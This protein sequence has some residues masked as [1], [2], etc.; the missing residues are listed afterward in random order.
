MKKIIFFLLILLLPSV[1]AADPFKPYLHNPEVPSNPG[2]ELYGRYSTSLF[3]GAATYSYTIVVPSGRNGLTPSITIDYNNQRA[4]QRSIVGS[5][6]QITNNYVFRDVNSTPNDTTDDFFT[7]VLNGVHE[8]VYDDGYRVKFDNFYKI[9]NTTD[10]LVTTKSGVQYSFGTKVVSDSRTLKWYLDNITDTYGNQIYYS[11]STDP[12]PGDINAVYLDNITYNN[13]RTRKIEFSY[14]TRPDIRRVYDQG[15]LFEESSRLQNISVYA[16]TLVRSYVLDYTQTVSASSLSSISLFGNDGG[17]L[18][19]VSFEYHNTTTNYTKHEND[20]VVPT[21]FSSASGQDFGSRLVDVNNDGYLDVLESRYDTGIQQAWIHNRL[22]GFVI[23]DDYAPPVWIAAGGDIS[24]GVRFVDLNSD[25]L[26]D[27]IQSEFDASATK[28]VYLNNGSGWVGAND[29]WAAPLYFKFSNIDAGSRLVDFNADGRVDIIQ[30]EKDASPVH[31]A[32]LNNGSG[33]E[34]V[35][36]KWIAPEFFIESSADTGTR[37][38]DINGDGLV[39]VIRASFLGVENNSAY[40]NN[41]TGWLYSSTW[42]SPLNFTQDDRLDTGVRLVDLNS[43]GLVDMVQSYKD[44]SGW[45]QQDKW[46]TPEIFS[47]N[48]ENIGR[49]IADF[50]GD[51]LG[52]IALVVV[53]LVTG[54]RIVIKGAE[55]AFKAAKASRRA[56]S[57]AEISRRGGI[58]ENVLDFAKTKSGDLVWLEKG[59]DKFGMDHIMKTRNIGQVGSHFSNFG[60]KFDNYQGAQ[61][62]V[63]QTARSGKMVTTKSGDKWFFKRLKGGKFLKVVANKEGKIITAH[64]VGA[65]DF[66]KQLRKAKK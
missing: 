36:D 19:N 35:S 16:P 22:G 42:S 37:L 52:D 9:E 10:W 32:Y 18:N 48:G 27:I 53:P 24:N 33:W 61:K 40:L 7:L 12:N 44:G 49:R 59:S 2:L 1:Y 39:D 54:G 58:A 64:P 4:K 3:P 50:N 8:L 11:Y 34:D 63:M 38:T 46:R 55:K 57:L 47:S 17:Y 30:S 60:S 31:K 43:D 13:D 45:V 20:Y 26:Q 51:G 29:T 15:S 21:K 28:N 41:G 5:G 56:E 66:G 25:G 14:E 62:L 23:D 6:W 65:E